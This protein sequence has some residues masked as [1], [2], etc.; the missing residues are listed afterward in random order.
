METRLT[1]L[2]TAYEKRCLQ[3][4]TEANLADAKSYKYVH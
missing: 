3:N 4:K 2:N 1:L